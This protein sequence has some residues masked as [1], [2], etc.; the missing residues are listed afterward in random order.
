MT[1]FSMLMSQRQFD[2]MHKV[3]SVL[4]KYIELRDLIRS[5]TLEEFELLIRSLEKSLEEAGENGN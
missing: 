5:L 1:E 2:K 4:D 3:A